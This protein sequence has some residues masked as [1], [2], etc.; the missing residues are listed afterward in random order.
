M[1]AEVTGP[2]L[3]LHRPVGTRSQSWEGSQSRTIDHAGDPTPRF[4]CE[5]FLNR[6]YYSLLTFHILAPPSQ[7]R[8]LSASGSACVPT[9][10][11]ES[12]Q[13]DNQ[14]F[15][16]LVDIVVGNLQWMSWYGEGQAVCRWT[17]AEIQSAAALHAPATCE[18]F[19]APASA[20][21]RV[22]AR[23]AN[24]NRSGERAVLPA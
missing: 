15:T 9:G 8:V 24:L 17:P 3:E 18:S 23:I 10:R 1:A 22:G 13:K 7:P 21:A 20:P 6:D 5:D 19:E 11:S 14:W 4:R 2:S 16:C 12:Q